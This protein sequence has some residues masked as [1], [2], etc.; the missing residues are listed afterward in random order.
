MAVDSAPNAERTVNVVR[1]GVEAV[2]GQS[3]RVFS[4]IEIGKG[5]NFPFREYTPGSDA[6]PAFSLV[7]SDQD[8]PQAP[9]LLRSP[10]IH[11]GRSSEVVTTTKPDNPLLLWANKEGILFGAVNIKG[12]NLL[13]PKV[14][15]DHHFVS[16]FRI[17][18][19]QADGTLAHVLKTS[20]MFSDLGIEAESIVRVIK[21]E[22]LI[23]DGK[24]C[25]IE[26]FKQYLYDKAVKE[27]EDPPRKGIMDRRT[28]PA[29]E[30]LG[31]IKQYLDKADLYFTVRGLQVQ[32]RPKDLLEVQDKQSFEKMMGRVFKFI[33]AREKMEAV[34]EGRAPRI[35]DAQ[36][37]TDLM[38]YFEEYL[39]KR[40]AKNVA[41]MHNAGLAHGFL[42]SH[43][44]S[45]A[46]SIYDVDS[47]SQ[48]ADSGAE[49]KQDFADFCRSMANVFFPQQTPGG[50][51]SSYLRSTLGPRAAQAFF[52]NFTKVYLETRNIDLKTNQNME[53]YKKETYEPS[54]IE[55]E[56][57][58]SQPGQFKELL[59]I[60]PSLG[61]INRSAIEDYVI[62]PLR[63]RLKANVIF[64]QGSYSGF[65]GQ[66]LIIGKGI[67]EGIEEAIKIFI[68]PENVQA[69][70]EMNGKMLDIARSSAA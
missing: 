31:K 10:S 4:G 35:L 12:N 27:A 36:N 48:V 17:F 38:F 33:N 65:G 44:V 60:L 7:I 58:K 54:L 53:R 62:S 5:E 23:I 50:E 1:R 52:R 37:E 26:Q 42:T 22:E 43:N 56:R 15:L 30:D 67:S 47:V 66:E 64:Y 25:N 9:F 3:V 20:Q 18:G 68:K 69:I 39:P 45:L 2:K 28:S 61:E 32:E 41:K 63:N 14:E 13:D 46:G 16:G 55:F 24:R 6:T 11:H 21:P 49:I 70:E 40:L 59:K 34:R 51:R 8:N 29:K 19:L 57:L